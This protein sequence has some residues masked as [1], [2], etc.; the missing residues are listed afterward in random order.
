MRICLITWA[1]TNALGIGEGIDAYELAYALTR[2]N[3]Q[4]EVYAQK[5]YVEGLLP[6]GLSI[7]GATMGWSEVLWRGHDSFIY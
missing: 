5:V 2:L 3:H 1:F 4:V 6:K 7:K